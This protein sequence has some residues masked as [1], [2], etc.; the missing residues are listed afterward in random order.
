MA[1]LLLSARRH[2]GGLRLSATRRF[3]EYRTTSRVCRRAKQA[4]Q[5]KPRPRECERM[6]IA[7]FPHIVIMGTIV[8]LR[9]E[10]KFHKSPRNVEIS[11][12]RD[13]T[14]MHL[15]LGFIGRLR[16]AR[17]A[18]LASARHTEGTCEP[19]GHRGVFSQ[20]ERSML[21]KR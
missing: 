2:T 18:R 7:T 20:L 19:P 8:R 3:G 21:L 1:D 17:N 6:F 4:L 9:Q 11:V 15:P 10:S 14:P 5:L 12:I 16:P 13:R